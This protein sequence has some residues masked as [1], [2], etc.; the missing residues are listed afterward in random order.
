MGK[1][2]NQNNVKRKTALQSSSVW[3]VASNMKH[4]IIVFL[5]YAVS[6]ILITLFTKN[7][8]SAFLPSFLVNANSSILDFFVLGVI[9]YYFEHQRQSK[10]TIS[11]LLEDLEN[12][13]T[14]EAVELKIKKIKII[15]QLNSKGVYDMQVP[16][17]NLSHLSTIKYLE[18]NGAELSGLIVSNPSMRDCEFINCSIQGMHV[19]NGKVKNVKFKNCKLK[20]LK[21]TKSKFLNVSFE[22]C[23]L[24]G[25]DFSNAEMRSCIIKNC[26]LRSVNYTNADLRSANLLESIN[27]DSD[28]LSEAKNLNYLVCDKELQE[29][30]KATKENVK[31]AVVDPA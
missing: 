4:V 23:Y 5:L 31:F 26:D 6:V 27:I 30:I 1:I 12:L 11:E 29:K 15:R 17:M 3:R 16:R 14:H 19:E 21:A 13:S 9:L 25:G 24:E 20:N 22:N 28:K 18:F 7:F 2:K 10:E 8:N